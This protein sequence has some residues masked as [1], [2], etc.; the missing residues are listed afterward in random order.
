MP[1]RALLG[2]RAC[3]TIAEA[4]ISALDTAAMAAGVGKPDSRRS[5]SHTD[6]GKRTVLIEGP[7]SG[8]TIGLILG[9]AGSFVD[10]SFCALS[11]CPG[12]VR[13]LNFPQVQPLRQKPG[14]PERA[15]IPARPDRVEALASNPRSRESGCCMERGGGWPR[16]NGRCVSRRPLHAVPLESLIPRGLHPASRC[17]QHRTPR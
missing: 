2:V 17:D 15:T 13:V 4:W 14:V 11:Q 3:H 5:H 8:R 7:P 12:V 16:R 6:S 9:A 10:A 1:G